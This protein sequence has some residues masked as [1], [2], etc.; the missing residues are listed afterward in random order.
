[1]IDPPVNSTEWLVQSN[2][3]PKFSDSI[4][5]THCHA[6]H[7]AGTFQ[8]ILEEGRVTIYTTPTVMDSFL[9]KYSSFS[10][11]SVE[12]LKKLFT[13]RPVYMGRPFYLHGGEFHIFYSVHS[14]PT[15]GFRITFQDKT[16]VYSSDHQG[17][18][19]VQKD[20][21]DKEIITASRYS[22]LRNFPWSSDVIYHEA[23]IAPLH[24]PVEYLNSLPE[25]VQKKTVVYHIAQKDFPTPNQTKLTRATFGIENTLY[26]ETKST[27]YEEAYRTLDVLKHF[28]F[29]QSIT[30]AKAQDF[31]SI[32]EKKTFQRG[33]KIIQKGESG[34]YFYIIRTGNARVDAGSLV[35]S[36]YLGAYEYF[37]EVALLSNTP[38]T[39]DIVAETEVEAYAIERNRFV[40]FIS[41]TEFEQVLRRLIRNRSEETWNI[42]V[43]NPLFEALTDYQRMWLESAL[44]AIE[45]TSA[46]DIIKEGE[47][48]PGLYI[49][50]E[51]IVKV[52][53][54]GKAVAELKKGNIIGR[55]DKF[56]RGEHASF[57]FSH[58]DPVKLFF[59]IAQRC[60]CV[61]Q[62]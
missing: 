43:S 12:F 19:K 46:D 30:P 51:G 50:R 27:E 33:E 17:D 16:F 58:T 28:D 36:K 4:L 60:H 39:A 18:P 7:D 48:L 52:S 41:G 13:Y 40:N 9:R 14:I 44:V 20:M 54:N 31:L 11:E 22:Q 45:N 24:T 2:V 37:G 47:A 34:K 26:F 53:R 38:R 32:V 62:T 8:K 35:R 5:L 21:F 42:L 23:G 1:M 55:F 25:D 49:L 56:Q 10:G 15:I 29:F 57:T 59:H 3:N 6:D 61:Y